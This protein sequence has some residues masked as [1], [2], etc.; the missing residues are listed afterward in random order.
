[1]APEESIPFKGFQQ[2]DLELIRIPEA[3]FT[4]LLPLIEKPDELRLL[5]Y[6]FWHLE[7]QTGKVRYFRLPEMAADPVLTEW[8]GGITKIARCLEGLVTLG[9]IL[10]ADLAWL[11]E[12]Y[13]FI[14]GPQG[15]AAVQVIAAGE[16]QGSSADRPPA[17]LAGTRPNIFTLYEENIGPITPMMAEILKADEAEYPA[18]WI[19]DAI[20]IAVARNARNWKYVQAILARWQKEGR[21]NEQNQRDNPQDPGNYRE[22]WLGND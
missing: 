2:E 1:M 11:N 10:K 20:R 17:H 4:Q 16:W 6:L 21:G 18:C 15:R 12:T 19:E 9:A 22:S 8:F 5:L 3:F 7:H 13:Y 14:N